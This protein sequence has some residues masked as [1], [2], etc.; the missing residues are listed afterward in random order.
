MGI[1]TLSQVL[2]NE[3]N[4]ALSGL[5]YK[6]TGDRSLRFDLGA[7]LYN[8][9][10]IFGATTGG[11]QNNSNVLD[12]SRV[13]FKLGKSF[14]NNN[15]IVTFGGDLDFNLGARSGV[16]NNFQW[17]PDLNIEIILT[18]DRKLRAIIFNKNSLDISGSNFGRRNRTGAS[19]SYRRDFDKLWAKKEKEV[20]VS[21]PAQ[22]K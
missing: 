14:L 2:T 15:V 6:I 19:I 13:N 12:R 5:L 3:V 8:S 17:L 1:N 21:D 20:A 11:V 7:S 9:S 10:S 22:K 16:G 4:K 18:K